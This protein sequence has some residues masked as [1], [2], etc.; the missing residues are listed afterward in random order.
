MRSRIIIA[1]ALGLATSVAQAQTFPARPREPPAIRR[2][3]DEREARPTGE[4]N[5]RSYALGL[6]FG[7]QLRDKLLDVDPT[8]VSRGIEDALDGREPLL[9]EHEVRAAIS[10]LQADMKRRIAEARG[11]G[12]E[13]NRMAGRA[14][15]AEN[16]R[17]PGVV[18]LP[19]GLQ[20]RVM[21]AG[22]GPR[23]TRDDTVL[24][25]YRGTLV[26][27][28]EFDSSSARGEPVALPVAGLIPGWSEALQL[29]PAGSRWQLFIP[30]ELAYGARGTGPLIGP[31]AA[32]VF[33]VELIA[34]QEA[35]AGRSRGAPTA[36]AARSAPATVE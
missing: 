1:L 2:A 22:D 35:S 16:G 3:G 8:T 4:R 14:F 29:M 24:C 6:E 32:L 23:P 18:T 25:R 12:A 36:A 31:D 9:S 11:M 10:D 20:Y 7:R 13:D 34:I 19:S 27:G 21:K 26:S 17:K 33:E 28:L 5:V 15:L 30:P